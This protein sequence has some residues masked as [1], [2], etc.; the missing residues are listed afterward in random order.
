[1][2]HPL[3]EPPVVTLEGHWCCTTGGWHLHHNLERLL[4]TE[5]HAYDI[6]PTYM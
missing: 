3:M 5:A 6:G 1:M 4:G 2:N